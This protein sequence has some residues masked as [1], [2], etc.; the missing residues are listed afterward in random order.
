MQIREG[1]GDMTT[2]CFTYKDTK[3]L[4]YMYTINISYVYIIIPEYHLLKETINDFSY[5]KRCPHSVWSLYYRGV[6]YIDWYRAIEGVGVGMERVKVSL[7]RSGGAN[8]V[9]ENPVTVSNRL[10]Y[11]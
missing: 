3:L 9:I 8:V 6:N 11:G 5:K 4:N 1:G 7:I 10:C 2:I